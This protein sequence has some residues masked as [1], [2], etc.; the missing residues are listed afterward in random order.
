M[1]LI[2]SAIFVQLVS[3]SVAVTYIWLNFFSSIKTEMDE[4]NNN[5]LNMLKKSMIIAIVLVL[6]SCFLFFGVSSGQ[7]IDRAS[8][9][10]LCFAVSWAVVIAAYMIGVL[11]TITTGTKV[12]ARISSTK[13]FLIVICCGAAGAAVCSWLIS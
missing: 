2:I 9:M 4:R 6:A 12:S 13:A 5:L 10:C 3:I 8:K 7:A 1:G 11:K